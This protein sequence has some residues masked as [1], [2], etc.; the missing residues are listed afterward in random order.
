MSKT[1]LHEK[2]V[3]VSGAG[4]GIGRAIALEMA[5]LGACVVVNDI[6]KDQDN[7]YLAEAVVK[8]IE[9]EDGSALASVGSI[10]DPDAAEGLVADA[11]KRFGRLDCVVNNAGIVRDKMFH[12]MER[13]DWDDVISVNLMGAYYISRAAASVFRE[14]ASGCYVNLTST[15]GLVGNVGQA[16][17]S[18]AK[19]GL[20]GLSK[21][22]A[23]DMARY[24]V[25]SNCIAPFAWS[26]MTSSIP[27]TEENK[28]RIER[29]QKMKPEMV[30]PLVAYLV[31]DEA[32]DVTGQVFGVRAN[33]LFLFSQPRVL[34]SVHHSD[35]WDVE[36]IA[37]QAMPALSASFYPMD[38]SPSL[39]SWEP[40]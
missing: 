10:S 13:S 17:Y 21:S 29:M 24:N 8:E 34:R 6:A 25:R 14:Q 12:K 37:E 18:A 38:T 28:G 22:I 16:N 32:K 33:E 40:I 11:V 7:Q 4:Q 36:S 35:G 19:L 20:V 23:L 1:D 26:A 39:F 15:S 9:E 30:A 5:Q 3:I 2:V 27:A 31:S